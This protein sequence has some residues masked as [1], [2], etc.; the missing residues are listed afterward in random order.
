MWEERGGKQQNVDTAIVLHKG[1]IG[2][3]DSIQGS[4]AREMGM[5]LGDLSCF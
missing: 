5:K 2:R 1:D 4:C 3:G